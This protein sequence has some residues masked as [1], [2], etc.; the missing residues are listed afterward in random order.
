[1]G[2]L[3]HLAK[4]GWDTVLLERK[5]LTSGTT[6]H[7]AGL[8]GQLRASVNLTRMG[9]YTADLYTKLETET[10]EKLGFKQNGALG[11]ALSRERFIE[12]KRAASMG[13]MAG[14]DIHVL[15]PSECKKLH[16]LV[17]LDKVEG[18]VFL[19]KD[20]QADPANV[21]L[22]LAKGARMSGARVF[23]DTK[24]TAI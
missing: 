12:L 1:C 14:L 6:W 20:G 10:G 17:S 9:I 2:V 3:Y 4:A 24:V 18:G 23:E 22:A 21:A 7:A 11:V 19:P 5:K 8:I 15:S 16:P 13:R